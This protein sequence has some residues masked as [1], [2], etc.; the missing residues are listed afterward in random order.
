MDKLR[1]SHVILAF[2][3]IFIIGTLGY[4]YIEN[5][6]WIDSAFMT[7]ITITTVGYREVGGELSD[8][9]KIFTMF[10]IMAGFGV[11]AVSLSHFA[12]LIMRGELNFFLGKIRMKREITQLTNHYI[13]AGY[14]RTGRVIAKN[15]KAKKIPYVVIDNDPKVLQSSVEENFPYIIGD[16]SD[17]A[18]LKQ[19]GVS[20]AKGFVAVMSSDASNAF[21]IMSARVSNPFLQ[22]TAR[23]LESQS[24]RK[25]KIAGANKVIAPYDLGGHRISQAITNP[26]ASDFIEIVEDVE[27]QHIEMADLKINAS[28]K[29]KGTPISNPIFKELDLLVIGVKKHEAEFIFN[30]KSDFLIEENYHLILMGPSR[31]V[32]QLEST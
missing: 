22:I 4:Y 7:V 31:S 5:W 19:T 28:S 16:A 12:S 26:H 6:S 9:G 21:A 13:I 30:P 27:A 32:I 1:I 20:K 15:L 25:L 14:G 11:V 10:L 24:I 29:L 2:F 8:T 23:A 18:I 3:S 17:E